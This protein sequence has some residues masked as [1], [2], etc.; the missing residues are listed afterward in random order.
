[1]RVG[2][3][4]L[5]IALLAGGVAAGPKPDAGLK[6]YIAHEFDKAIDSCK[7]GDDFASRTVL[8]LSFLEKYNLY[9]V[10]SDRD[11]ARMYLKIL[12]VD[13]TLKHATTIDRFLG[14]EGNPHGNKE[15]GKLLNEA[16][17]KARTQDDVMLMTTFLLPYKGTDVNKSALYYI[18]KRLDPVRDYVSGGGMMPKADQKLFSNRKLI[19][20]IV[21]AL[22][23]KVTDSYAKSCLILI[24][25]PALSYLEAVEMIGPVADSIVGIKKAMAKRQKKHPESTWFSAYGQAG[26]SKSW[27]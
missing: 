7:G 26:E 11:Q 10:K 5:L 19:E 15:A 24:E 16:F 2:S 6:H 14:V 1:M 27:P 21:K 18:R 4:V 23:D 9:K 12:K 17:K 3:I 22:A 13:V 20:P 8:G 25:E